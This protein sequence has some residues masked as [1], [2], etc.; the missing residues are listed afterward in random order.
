M[1]MGERHI[2]DLPEPEPLSSSGTAQ[3]KTLSSDRTQVDSHL[4]AFY[5]CSQTSQ[6][7]SPLLCPRRCENNKHD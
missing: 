4:K 5:C 2:V 6:P 3:A 7:Y 1:V